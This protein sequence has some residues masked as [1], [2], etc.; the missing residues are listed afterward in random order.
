MARRT[1][2]E[3]TLRLNKQQF[4]VPSGAYLGGHEAGVDPASG[5]PIIEAVR[6]RGV[7]KPWEER[8][9]FMCK[10]CGHLHVHSPRPGHR[11]AHC[12]QRRSLSGY[13]QRGYVLKEVGEDSKVKV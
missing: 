8:L 13:E 2:T 7:D 12:Y 10:H 4:V 9:V 5:A 1:R 3:T 11:Q 6:V